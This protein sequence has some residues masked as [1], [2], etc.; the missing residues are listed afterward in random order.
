MPRKR[1]CAKGKIWDESKRSCTNNTDWQD[2]GY[3][4]A[5]GTKG[6]KWMSFS[7]NSLKEMVK[8]NQ[9]P[10]EYAEGWNETLQWESEVGNVIVGEKCRTDKLD[11]DCV[12]SY[13]E[14][15]NEW[16]E[17]YAS[18]IREFAEKQGVKLKQEDD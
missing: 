16:T 1:P 13:A 14:A 18:F 8:E 12:G 9:S 2:N 5:K 11:D 6:T 17:G 4:M 7:D 10:S 15:E 3:Q